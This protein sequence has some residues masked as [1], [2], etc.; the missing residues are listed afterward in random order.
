[1]TEQAPFLPSF[2]ARHPVPP[3]DIR[4]TILGCGSSGGVPRLGGSDGLGQWG[5]C[6]PS[7]PKNR[8]RRCSVLVERQGPEGVT[9]VLI[10][11]GPDLRE[12]LLS[13]RIGTLDAVLFTHDHADHTHGIDDLR[14]V[15]FNI[16]RRLPVWMDA[17]TRDI[18]MTRFGYTF[19]T[20]P[21]SLYPPILE[22]NLIEKTGIDAP[23]VRIDGAG[24]PIEAIPFRVEHGSIMALGFRIGG[25]AYLPDVSAMTEEAWAAVEALDLWILDALRYTP[26]PTHANVETALGWIDHAG[27]R[28]AIL[29]NMHVDLD[30][31]T[32]SAEMPDRVTLAYDGRVLDGIGVDASPLSLAEGVAR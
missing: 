27:P 10:D 15:V 14:L 2:A 28:R 9:R 32:L 3:D 26:H 8:R 30:Y 12:Q 22:L 24:G 25:V 18:L 7:N 11:A 17:A 19:E 31:E 13:A 16:R 23:P 4:F 21:G 5:A 1:M 20:P 29:T 6:D